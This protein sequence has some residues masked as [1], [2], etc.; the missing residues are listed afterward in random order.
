MFVYG[1]D[2]QCGRGTGTPKCL[3]TYNGTKGIG[4]VMATGYYRYWCFPLYRV[5][6][7]A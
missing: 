4:Q 2:N 6:E 5:L 7:G 3:N 1:Y